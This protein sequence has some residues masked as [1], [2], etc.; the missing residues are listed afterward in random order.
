MNIRIRNSQNDP[1]ANATTIDITD[2][3]ERDFMDLNMA[4]TFSLGYVRA[5]SDNKTMSVENR[6]TWTELARRLE[7]M[8]L[9]RFVPVQNDLDRLNDPR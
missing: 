6:Q 4:I 1:T 5:Q 8:S 2:L 9:D 7:D 3:T